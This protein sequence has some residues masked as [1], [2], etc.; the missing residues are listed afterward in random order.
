MTTRVACALTQSHKV[1]H[2]LGKLQTDWLCL[3]FVRTQILSKH[4]EATFCPN[5]AF[6]KT[7]IVFFEPSSFLSVALFLW[8][9]YILLGKEN[10]SQTRSTPPL[11]ARSGSRN[12]ERNQRPTLAA[13]TLSS[14]RCGPDQEL[15]SPPEM[16]GGSPAAHKTR[17]VMGMQTYQRFPWC[18]L[19]GRIFSASPLNVTAGVIGDRHQKEMIRQQEKRS[20]R[21]W[22]TWDNV[23]WQNLQKRM[24]IW[25]FLTETPPQF[26]FPFSLPGTPPND[27][28]K[29]CF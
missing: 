26:V 20:P 27:R 13:Q 25:Y 11:G 4:Q 18:C 21:D 14:G 23:K 16:A 3:K 6:S 17:G 24:V 28:W 29:I 8:I 7:M 22:K 5:Q 2:D 9:P 19:P 15:V 12:A 1:I 10:S